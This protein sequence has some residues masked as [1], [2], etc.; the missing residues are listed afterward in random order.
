MTVHVMPLTV[1]CAVCQVLPCVVQLCLFREPAGLSEER[2]E[3]ESVKVA[4]VSLIE[5]LAL[6]RWLQHVTVWLLQINITSDI[7]FN[8]TVIQPVFSSWKLF[9]LSSLMLSVWLT[10]GG[11]TEQ[12]GTPCLKWGSAWL[13]STPP[14]CSNTLLCLSHVWRLSVSAL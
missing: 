8:T 6:W 13:N 1:R 4:A 9:H 11:N 2:S 12:R 3:V 14:A 5:S 7:W 10:L